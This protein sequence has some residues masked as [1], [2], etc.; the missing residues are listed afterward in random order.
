MRQGDGIGAAVATR[1]STRG[2]TR[3]NSGKL[4]VQ[5]D[6][7]YTNSDLGYTCSASDEAVGRRASGQTTSTGLRRRLN[8][9]PRRTLD[10]E[11]TLSVSLA[12]L[13]CFDEAKFE[14]KLR[15]LYI[16]GCKRLA[17]M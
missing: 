9:A 17:E 10:T 16:F 12:S 6:G 1:I 15:M 4:I 14:S 13:C 11:R 7:M 2:L 5:Q 8:V 3:N